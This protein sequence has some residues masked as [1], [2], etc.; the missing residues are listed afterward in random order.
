MS[1]TQI[2]DPNE[3]GCDIKYGNQEKSQDCKKKEK[4]VFAYKNPALCIVIGE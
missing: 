2:R 4:I 3:R 1:L